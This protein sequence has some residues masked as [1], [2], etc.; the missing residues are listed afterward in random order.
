MMLISAGIMDRIVLNSTVR[1]P[2]AG[3]PRAEGVRAIE[4][5]CAYAMCPR[6]FYLCGGA[7][8]GAYGLYYLARLGANFFF[9]RYQVVFVHCARFYL[10]VET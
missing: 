8:E 10:K 3:K 9:L 2:E 1:P 7:E 6:T 4:H 5:I